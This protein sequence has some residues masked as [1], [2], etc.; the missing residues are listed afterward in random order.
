MVLFS[1]HS[2]FDLLIFVLL[3]SVHFDSVKDMFVLTVYHVPGKRD[4]CID[5]QMKLSP[6][7]MNIASGY[8]NISDL[9]KEGSVLQCCHA[10]AGFSV[11]VK[12][13]NIQTNGF[14]WKKQAIPSALRY[15]N[16]VSN[17]S[18]LQQEMVGKLIGDA[19]TNGKL[20]GADSMADS[21]KNTATINSVPGTNISFTQVKISV[22]FQKSCNLP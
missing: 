14:D 4:R 3:I 18:C 8:F 19:I 17:F 21:V 12:I 5:P 1:R 2:F 22:Y 10:A 13:S 15:M 11:T 6:Y 7:F 16:D 20:E 9:L